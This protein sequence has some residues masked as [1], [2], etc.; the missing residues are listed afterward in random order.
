M[1]EITKKVLVLAFQTT[2]GKEARLTINVPKADLDGATVGAAM[3]AVIG[4]G[5]YGDGDLAAVKAGAKYV[6]Q[7]VEEITL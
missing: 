3:D 7:E 6:I 2:K 5:A 4:S 1:A